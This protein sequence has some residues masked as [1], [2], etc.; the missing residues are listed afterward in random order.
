MDRGL[1]IIVLVAY[2]VIAYVLITKVVL[3]ATHG[4]S[5]LTNQHQ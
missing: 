1:H 5:L 3:L 2:G 4:V